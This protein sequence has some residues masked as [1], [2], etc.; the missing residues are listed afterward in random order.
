M[1]PTLVQRN[2]RTASEKTGAAKAFTCQVFGP[3]WNAFVEKWA[4]V[5]YEFIQHALGP[6][7]TEPLPTIIPMHDGDHSSG[8]T[9][10]FDIDSGQIT[11]CRSIEG[12]PGTTLEK[13]THEMTHG[14]LAKFPEG[15]PFYEE[16][17]VDYSVWIMAHAPVWEDLRDAMIEAASY[18]I[19]QRR[20]R[21]MM[22]LSDYD[23]KRWA[24]GF[25]AM[26]SRGPWIISSLKM[27]KMQGDYSW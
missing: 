9:A 24:G 23:R 20:E 3:E 22:D 25:Y 4:P 13:L 10:S 27:K 18:N 7:G 5:I 12:L 17:F 1:F 2:L 19:A 11:L 15:D 6:Y 26:V 8:A 14:S 21:A 16:G